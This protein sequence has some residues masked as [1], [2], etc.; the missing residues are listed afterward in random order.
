MHY[1]IIARDY[2][3]GLE[4]RQK[5]R[6]AHLEYGEKLKEEGKLLYAVAIMK[7]GTMAGSVMVMDFESGEDLENWKANEPY[8][9]G[10]VWEDLEITECA[11][12]PLFR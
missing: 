12:P 7:E 6:P 4:N 8:V 5:H 2:P 3:N 1:L 10:K 9:K 11:I